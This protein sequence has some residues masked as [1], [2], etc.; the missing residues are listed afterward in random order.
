[1]A[2]VEIAAAFTKETAQSSV[3]PRRKIGAAAR[4]H[5]CLPP[6]RRNGGLLVDRWFYIRSSWGHIA[7]VSAFGN[8]WNVQFVPLALVG[9]HLNPFSSSQHYEK[10][11][12]IGAR[13]FL[14]SQITFDGSGDPL[15]VCFAHMYNHSRE[16]QAHHI[17]FP[18][19]M[20][21]Y[22]DV[23]ERELQRKNFVDLERVQQAAHTNTH[24]KKNT[25]C[26]SSRGRPFAEGWRS[27]S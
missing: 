24:L 21:F 26:C 4:L 14:M 27:Y 11:N 16:I 20:L 7:R 3:G 17:P 22:D 2:V 9:V 15:L 13:G 12:C 23:T 1:M 6:T 8:Q 18:L 5:A 19:I 10:H 25:K